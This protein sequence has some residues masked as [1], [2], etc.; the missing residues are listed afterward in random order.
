MKLFFCTLCFVLLTV[1]GFSQKQL[2]PD[3]IYL[4]AGQLR[5]KMPAFVAPLKVIPR[6]ISARVWAG[7]SEYKLVSDID[8]LSKKYIK[9]RIFAYVKGDSMFLND[10]SSW[11]SL[12]LTQGN[13]IVFRTCDDPNVTTMGVMFGLV[14][15]LAYSAAAHYN[16]A[17]VSLRTGNVRRFSK[18]YLEERLK[19]FP[20]LQKKFKEEGK[21]PPVETLLMYVDLLNERVPL[22]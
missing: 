17:I 2:F 11:F 8:S 5:S 22:D 14:G 6:E 15:A 18:A 1:A 16:L 7:G 10:M 19:E 3:G 13:F 4:N 9:N 20:D 12:S 21:K